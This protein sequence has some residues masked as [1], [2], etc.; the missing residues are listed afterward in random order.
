MT[1]IVDDFEM[2]LEA[3]IDE[4]VAHGGNVYDVIDAL[5]AKSL[6]LQDEHGDREDGG[7]FDV[8]PEDEQP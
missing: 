5:D 2:R 6:A 8:D 4:W 3:L 7:E 1:G